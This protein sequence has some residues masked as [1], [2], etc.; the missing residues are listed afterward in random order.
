MSAVKPGPISISGLANFP[1]FEGLSA[2]LVALI[3]PEMRHTYYD[4][5]TI[6][7]HGD[8]CC[9][10]IVVT[11]GHVLVHVDDVCI[12][13]RTAPCVIGE[14]ALID[15]TTR[16]ASVTAEGYVEAFVI[17]PSVAH[18]LMADQVFLRNL[19]RIL[20]AKL[21]EA[22]DE[23]AIRYK[24]EKRLFGEFSAHVSRQVADGLISSGVDYGKA[25]YI[26]DAVILQSDIR[27]FTKLSANMVPE[28]IAEQLSA[29]LSAAVDVIHAH[30]GLIDKFVGDAVL[31]VWGFLPDVNKVLKA[32]RCAE[33]L[34]K[35]AGK[36][37]FGGSPVRVGVGLNF[38]RV[39]IG[40]VGNDRKRQFTV[41]G[42]PVNL[43]ARFES[44]SK[45]LH[46]PIILGAAFYER[47]P[48][49]IQDSVK[50]HPGEIIKGD[51]AQTLYSFDPRTKSG[52]K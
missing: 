38:G 45:E 1:L 39:F 10:L 20:S 13:P 25:R 51:Q 29:Y 35:V 28:E 37:A 11:R 26:Q 43:A 3:S 4:S 17:P 23:R 50:S 8:P 49:T 14:L 44:K 40:N 27:D 36:M 34:V 21:R 9:D 16:S 22:T 46:T 18:Q 12:V 52:G 19:V 5:D 48:P 32:F 33:E 15:G 30:D 6:C 41:L 47:L 42:T 7:A 2:E 24:N 31:A